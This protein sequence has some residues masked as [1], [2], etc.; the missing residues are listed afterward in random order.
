MPKVQ[1]RTARRIVTGGSI[2]AVLLFG[3]LLVLSSTFPPYDPVSAGEIPDGVSYGSVEIEGRTVHF[4]E[5]GD[6]GNPMV[7]FVHGTP[8]SLQAFSGYLA[9]RRLQARAHLVA[10]DRPGFGQSV[11]GNW[12]PGL[13]EQAAFMAAMRRVNRSGE[14]MVVV[15]HSLGGT[16][17]YRMGVDHP[18]DVQHLVVISSSID[19]VVGQ[20]RWYNHLGN[21][22]PVR[23][24][25]P[26]GLGK[27]NREIMPLK[28]ELGELAPLIGDM[29]P[30][31]TVIHGM[32]DRLVSFENLRFAEAKLPADRQRIVAVEDVGH[33]ILWERPDLILPEIEHAIRQARG[34]SS[35]SE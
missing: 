18:D 5:S 26:G 10:V 29:A 34:E 35:A 20:A 31:V 25:L 1:R 11:D 3:V 14:P 23:F 28:R 24:I 2:T 22:W 7:L 19:P 17:A 27:A 15:G 30:V 9:N 12:L 13:T 4:A 32:N 16:I 33:F 6:A 8:G 21:L